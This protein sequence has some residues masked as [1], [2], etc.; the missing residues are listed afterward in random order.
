M[1]YNLH[2]ESQG[3]DALRLQQLREAL[4]DARLHTGSSMV[5]V[6][7]DFNLDAGNDDAAAAL[8]TRIPRRCSAAGVPDNSGSRHD[9]NAG[10]VIDWIYV[11]ENVRSEGQ[12]HDTVRASDHLPCFR[13]CD[14]LTHVACLSSFAMSF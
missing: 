9:S 1:T 13:Y 4:H 8:H 3:K 10:V 7:G 11:S 6:A 5:I 14:F 2:L 12:V